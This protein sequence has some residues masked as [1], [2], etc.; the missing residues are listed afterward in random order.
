LFY[1]LSLTHNISIL[2]THINISEKWA[3]K[4]S[5]IAHLDGIIAKK[6]TEKQSLR[7][8]GYFAFDFEYFKTQEN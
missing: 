3:E 2:F 7:Q 1:P 5:E 6:I 4:Y 8:N